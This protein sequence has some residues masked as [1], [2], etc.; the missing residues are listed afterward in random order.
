MSY[1]ALGETKEMG[2]H[3]NGNPHPLLNHVLLCPAFVF[4]MIPPL[5]IKTKFQEF[6]LW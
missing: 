6:L 2:F 4:Q 5:S 1:T 3:A